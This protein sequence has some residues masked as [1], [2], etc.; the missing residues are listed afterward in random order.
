MTTLDYGRRRGVLAAADWS[1]A[2]EAAWSA[3]H[4]LPAEYVPLAVGHR[5]VLAADLAASTSLP[6]FT[7]SAM[8]GWAVAG[9]GPWNVVGTVLAGSTALAL[10]PGEAV[11]VATGAQVPV[12]TTAVLRSEDGVMHAGRLEGAVRIG[13]NLRPAGEESGPGEVLVACGTPLSPAHLGLAAAGG[14][15]V[16]PVVRRPTAAVLVLGDELLERGVPGGGR[17]RDALGPQ[18]PSWLGVLGLDVHSVQRVGDTLAD[19]VRALDSVAGSDLVVTTGSTA[20]GPVDL[21]HSALDV[22]GSSYVVDSV[23]CRPGHPML[24][25]RPDRGG[26]VLGLPGNPQAAVAALLTLGSP[27]VGGLHGLQLADLELVR[28]REPLTAPAGSTRLVLA[29]R[30]D[31]GAVAV[32]HQGSAM[33]RGL[34]EAD[35]YLVVPP[36][37]CAADARLRWLPLPR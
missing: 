8:D 29:R 30:G 27:Y 17:V 2:R 35:G 22:V 26:A 15:D 3:A 24:L 5:R 10:A 20:A 25:A 21:L 12:G 4:P 31:A 9:G 36:G 11:V 32:H 13:D 6:A 34:A 37:G 33:L 7:S 23:R 1:A 19:V 14:Y 18:L 16:V 28:S